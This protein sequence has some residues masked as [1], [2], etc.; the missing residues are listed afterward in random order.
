MEVKTRKEVYTVSAGDRFGR[1]TVVADS[2]KRKNGYIVWTCRCDCGGMVDVDIRTLR[3]GTFRDCGCVTKLSGKFRDIT[4]RRFGM[5]TVVSPTGEIKRGQGYVWHCVCDC[6]GEADVPLQQLMVG[7]RKSCGCVSHPPVKEL[8]GRRF[9][10]LTAVSYAGKWNKMHHW[11]CRCDCGGE[12]TVLESHL[13]RGNVRSCGCTVPETGRRNLKCIEGTSI[14]ALEYVRDHL[15]SRNKSGYT[16]VFFATQLGKWVASI[17]FK[18]KAYHLGCFSDI[19][20]AVA[21][22]RVAEREMHQRFLDWYY[23][24]YLPRTKAPAPKGMCG[25]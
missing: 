16:G 7:H 15:N 11:N 10:M 13:L 3:R 2:G 21:V 22:R 24:E 9:G 1:L 6:G 12:T 25:I 20:D 14:V 23:S 19:R 5:L 17:N 4:G 18:G 8:A